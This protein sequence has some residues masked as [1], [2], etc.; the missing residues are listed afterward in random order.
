M[1]NNSKTEKKTF[2]NCFLKF[3]GMSTSTKPAT[4]LQN[5]VFKK[6]SGIQNIFHD[7]QG[8]ILAD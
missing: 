4:S 1:A 3:L 8:I 6:M 5:T 2:E 7:F